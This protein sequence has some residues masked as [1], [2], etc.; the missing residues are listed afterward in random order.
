MAT[1][2]ELHRMAGQ[3]TGYVI[4]KSQVFGSAIYLN[5]LYVPSKPH[6]VVVLLQLGLA[7]QP[8]IQDDVAWR[9]RQQQ[10][11]TDEKKSNK[12]SS[13]TFRLEQHP[14]T[15]VEGCCS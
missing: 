6:G 12:P 7:T 14:H 9:R 15:R 4:C 10:R 1:K 11:Y 13:L 8:V 2:E 3:Q 5:T